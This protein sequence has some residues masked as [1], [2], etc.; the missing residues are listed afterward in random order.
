MQRHLR[1]FAVCFALLLIAA[2]LVTP[3]LGQVTEGFENGIPASWTVSPPPGLSGTAVSGSGLSPTEGLHYGWISTGCTGGTS[4][5]TVAT[6]PAP[7]YSSALYQG[8]G[9]N[10]LPVAQG[11]GTPTV[12]TTLTSPS[13][14]F[15][16]SGTISFDVNFI[17]TDGTYD[18]A[19]YA[20]VTLIPVA[21]TDAST[22]T[23][24]V[25]NTTC[26]I[27]AAVPPVGLTNGAGILSPT[28]ASFTGASVTFGSTTYG[29]APKYGGGLG[30]PSAWIHV[31]HPVSAG[32]YQLQFLVAHVGDTNYPS[33][34]AIDNL[35]TP[36]SQT[37]TLEPGVTAIYPAGQD[38]SKWTPLNNLGGEQLTVTA[39][40]V[41]QSAFVTPAGFTGETCVPYKDFTEATGVPTCVEFQADCAQGTASTNDCSTFIYQVMTNYDLPSG[42][43]EIG[44][45]GGPDFLAFHGQS[46][47]PSP[48]APAQSIFLDYTV[49]RFDPKTAGGG[50]GITCFVATYTPGA[51]LITGT[52]STFSAF[53][54]F[55]LFV[56]NTK[57]NPVY[58]GLP[59]ILVWDFN[60]NL[61][62]PVPNLHLCNNPPSGTGCTTPWV[63]LRL[64]KVPNSSCPSG[65]PPT[66]P[67]PSFF[68]LG[69]RKG[70][71]VGEYVFVWDTKAPKNLKSCQV[72]VVLTFDSGL[73]VAPAKF[74]YK[75]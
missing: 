17:T 62:V 13:F 49:N 15:P 46:C 37:Q 65:F 75:F 47:P 53:E 33:A 69:L 67:L 42:L 55:E 45:I 11:L 68:N 16:N 66:G 31:S 34:L 51:P 63:N 44:A 70:D 19:D 71:E 12:E 9:T 6:T 26:D 29:G 4:C 60:T 73:I 7:Y 57:I 72:S 52:G 5:P 14:V 58:Q 24:F 38:N 64:I 2:A 22:A 21:G 43:N 54:G 50:A 25:A 3:A 1:S 35:Q 30:G 28:T 59:V 27:C 10:G 20:L 41:P 48:D 40:P 61:G 36:E 8:P 74:Q 32:S 56:S 39:V 23:L 18:F